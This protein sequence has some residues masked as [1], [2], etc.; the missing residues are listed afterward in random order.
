MEAR[1]RD[2]AWIAQR[3]T[4][5]RY[6]PILGEEYPPG[7]N[8]H[9]S[10][11][12]KVNA[13]VPVAGELMPLHLVLVSRHKH[14]P[15]LL[16]VSETWIVSERLRALV[17]QYE[18]G[19]HRFFR[20]S[21]QTR[22]GSPVSTTYSVFNICQSIDAIDYGRSHVHWVTRSDGTRICTGGAGD[23]ALI[24]KGLAIEGKHIWRERQQLQHFVFFSD[25]LKN[26]LEEIKIEKFV[27]LRV[28]E[29]PSMGGRS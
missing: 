21:I 1:D 10:D 24:V 12:L 27:F 6:C 3:S 25:A 29:V 16:Q 19:L 8:K 26:V 17:E 18:P 11:F 22:D 15:D 14:L 9:Q 2:M 23:D 4:L 7:V 28:G 5:N 20:I 13:G